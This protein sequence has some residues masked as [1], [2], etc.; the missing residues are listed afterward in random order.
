MALAI[1]LGLG[2]Y[3]GIGGGGGGNGAGGHGSRFPA[4]IYPPPVPAERPNAPQP[5]CPNPHGLQKPAPGDGP[6]V[7]HALRQLNGNANHDRSFT[8]PAYWPQLRYDTDPFVVT[9][10]AHAPPV[11]WGVRQSTQAHGTPSRGLLGP[12]GTACSRNIPLHSWVVVLG[13]TRGPDRSSAS[14]PMTYWLIEREGHWL[15]WAVY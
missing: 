1:G 5:D 13:P 9:S 2:L 11:P 12:P 15:L 7:V 6:A 14:L 3:F 4:A 8:D 10:G